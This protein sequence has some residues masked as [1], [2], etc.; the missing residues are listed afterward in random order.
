MRQVS[1]DELNSLLKRKIIAGEGIELQPII[2]EG[3][4]KL[5]I[6]VNK[7]ALWPVGST[8]SSD[9]PTSPAILFGGVWAAT[10]VGRTEV[11]VDPNDADFNAAGKTGGHKALQAHYHTLQKSMYFGGG[12]TAAWLGGGS[13]LGYGTLQTDTAGS[14]DSQNLPPYEAKFKWKRIA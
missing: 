4:F 10:C 3:V 12:T 8:Y 6:A 7:L 5:K 9:D 14:G 13:D 11:G 1:V 2:D